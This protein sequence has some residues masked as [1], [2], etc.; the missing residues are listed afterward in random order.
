MS[1]PCDVIRVC[2]GLCDSTSRHY[3]SLWADGK[4]FVMAYLYSLAVSIDSLWAYVK[5]FVKAHWDIL[6]LYGTTLYVRN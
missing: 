3:Y 4:V 5:A 2:K 6:I 1:E